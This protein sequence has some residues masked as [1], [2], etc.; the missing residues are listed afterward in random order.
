MYPT[1]LGCFWSVQIKLVI[2]HLV[3]SVEFIKSRKDLPSTRVYWWR[4]PGM[5]V[6]Y[7]KKITGRSKHR[8]G[9][10]GTTYRIHQLSVFGR[11]ENRRE[12]QIGYSPWSSSSLSLSPT[13]VQSVGGRWGSSGESY[14][15]STVEV[16][17]GRPKS[18][19]R[20]G[21]G[22]V[23]VTPLLRGNDRGS[24]NGRT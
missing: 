2:R 15:R 24:W 10:G 9:R 17:V 19:T 20:E 18:L 13:P 1:R 23:W 5:E 21:K 6:P 3:V 12:T 8:V 4:I 11:T 14:R 16:V 22:E 7:D